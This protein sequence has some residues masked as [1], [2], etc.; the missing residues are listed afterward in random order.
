MY[1]AAPTAGGKSVPASRNWADQGVRPPGNRKR[2]AGNILVFSVLMM[3]V[4]CGVLAFAVDLGYLY[5]LR[6]E[7]QRSADAAAL[8]GV[9]ALYQPDGSLESGWYY[10]APDPDAARIE[11][12]RFVRINPVFWETST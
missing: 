1:S 2:R 8:A 12:R 6:T 7:L 10:L 5:T 3:V 11:S 4:M 9:A